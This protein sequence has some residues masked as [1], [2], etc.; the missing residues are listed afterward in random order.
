MMMIL[1][2]IVTHGSS[3][4]R[5]TNTGVKSAKVQVLLSLWLQR[6]FYSIYTNYD[7]NLKNAKSPMPFNKL[8]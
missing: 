1:T 4:R 7:R 8:K 5:P 2:A 3:M 6:M